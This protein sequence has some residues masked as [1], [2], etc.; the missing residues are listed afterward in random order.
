MTKEFVKGL[1]ITLGAVLV[2]AFSEVPLVWSV[3]I[4]TLIGTAIVYT[5]KN[6]ILFLKSD[7]KP[8]T[9]S[10]INALSALFIA[11]GTGVIQAVASIAGTG[12]IDWSL[13]GKVVLSVTFT[14]LGSTFFA[15][16]N[17]EK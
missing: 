6:A 3:L 5:G 8:G 9:L 11:V 10:W 1:L 2:T 7:S 17:T 4:I 12:I 16:K 13:L 15:G 14:Y